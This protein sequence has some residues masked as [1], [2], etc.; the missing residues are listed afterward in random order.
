MSK[1]SVGRKLYAAVGFIGVLSLALALG[2]LVT[3]ARLKNE[4]TEITDVTAEVL[5][6]AG[7]IEYY[8]SDLRAG[9]RMSILAAAEQNR[10][11][12]IQKGQENDAQYEK[13]QRTIDALVATTRN[14]TSDPEHLFRDTVHGAD[15]LQQLPRALHHVSRTLAAVHHQ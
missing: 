7:Q 2:G 5:Y 4:V 8:I 15:I 6:Q 9:L 14:D 11:V 12:S 10:A 13:L 1:W 3:A